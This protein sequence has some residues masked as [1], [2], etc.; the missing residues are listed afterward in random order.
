MAA[1]VACPLSPLKLAVPVPAI[2]EITLMECGLNEGKYVGWTLGAADD[3]TKDGETLVFV[4]RDKVSVNN[5]CKYS[6]CIT[7]EYS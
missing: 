3:G 2:V 6:Y 1:E 7:W 5:G 4:H